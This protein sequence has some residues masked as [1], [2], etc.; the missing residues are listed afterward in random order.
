[1]EIVQ[2][3][4]SAADEVAPIFVSLG[5]LDPDSPYRM[6]VS[7]TNRGAAVARVELNESAYCD[8][9]DETGYLGQI[10]VDEKYAAEE[11]NIGLPGVGVQT[12]GQGTPAAAAGLQPGDRIVG[13]VNAKGEETK[14]EKFDDLRT[15]LL[16]TKPGDV[17]H[18][19]AY[20]ATALETKPNCLAAR[21]FI[22]ERIVSDTE[23]TSRAEVKTTE[24]VTAATQDAT[25]KDPDENQEEVAA[26]TEPMSET[27]VSDDAEKEKIAN[28]VDAIADKPIELKS[29]DQELAEL[30]EP[31]TLEAT[32]GVAPLAVLSPNGMVLDY[33]D[34]VNLRGLQGLNYLGSIGDAQALADY[35]AS[36]GKGAN[37]RKNNNDPASFL[38]SLAAV[39]NDTLTRWSPQND[40]ATASTNAPRASEIDAE[41]PGVNLRDGYWTFVAEESNERCAVFKKILL[42]RRLEVVKKYELARDGDERSEG[43]A[44]AFVKNNR[45]YHLKLSFSIRNVDPSTSRKVAYLQDGPNGLPLEGAWFASGRK[46]G[47]G[48]GTAYGMRDLTASVDDNR[49]FSII[50]CSN[51]AQGKTKPSDVQTI[52]F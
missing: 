32:L 45:A 24:P 43:A 26:S 16:A 52:D 34:Y 21:R 18:L 3:A 39:D 41:L 48:F 28:F 7:L 50:G 19:R 9:S 46:T 11:F 27:P 8:N 35:E 22:N 1:Q 51:I 12:V 4:K 25:A 49:N 17:V 14:I 10:V 2:E 5:S 15:A 29:L 38:T 20:R 37:V 23:K 30:G 42:E 40:A 36:R 6:L 47:P 31:E 13:L 33:A 44:D